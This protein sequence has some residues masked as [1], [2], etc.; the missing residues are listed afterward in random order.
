MLPLGAASVSFTLLNGDG[1]TTVQDATDTALTAGTAAQG[2]GA[3]LQLG[4]FSTTITDPSAVWI[5]IAGLGSANSSIDLRVGDFGAGASPDGFFSNTATFDDGSGTDVGL[6]SADTQ[7]AIRMY[8]TTSSGSLSTANF[9]TVTNTGWKFVA[10]SE[11][12]ST[13]DPLQLNTTSGTT[14]WQD[15]VNAF[16]TTI[17]AVPEPSSFALLGL[18]A[19]ALTSRR[20]K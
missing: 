16:K 8:D 13:N 18:G 5:P 1:S 10:L 11:T 15:D 4:Y 20:K 12:P 3:I 9:N 6:P 19:L 7:L 2:D 17:I 14:T